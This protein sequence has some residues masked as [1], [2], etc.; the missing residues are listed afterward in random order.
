LLQTEEVLFPRRV[1]EILGVNASRYYFATAQQH[2][3]GAAVDAG[4]SIA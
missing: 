3:A 1:E 4:R 2:S